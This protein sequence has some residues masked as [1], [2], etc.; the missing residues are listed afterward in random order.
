LPALARLAVPRCA[1]FCSLEPSGVCAIVQGLPVARMI[2]NLE[3]P[4]M[5]LAS[6]CAPDRSLA[7]SLACAVGDALASRGLVYQVDAPGPETGSLRLCDRLWRPSRLCRACHVHKPLPA[8]CGSSE[9]LWWLL[10]HG[11][12]ILIRGATFQPRQQS[13]KPLIW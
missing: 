5:L 3:E 13:Y 11:G 10:R 7:A 8:D 6:R 1:F 12:M 2:G 4:A 9:R